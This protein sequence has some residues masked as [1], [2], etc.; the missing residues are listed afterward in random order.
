MNT[1]FFYGF[2]R[3]KGPPG[4]RNL[5]VVIPGELS[6]N[7]WAIE[8]ASSTDHATAL[9]HKQG[10]GN[11]AR[12]R[13]LFRRLLKGI[14]I[15]P[16]VAGV[17]FLSSG[18][19]DY[20]PALLAQYATAHG[21]AIRCFSLRETKCAAAMIRTA[22]A[23]A[24]VMASRIA[25]EQRSPFGADAL[26]IGLNCAGT[27]SASGITSHL[28]CGRAMDRLNDAGATIL[29]SEIPEM[30]GLGTEFLSRCS[31]KGVRIKLK[32]IIE[33]HRRRLAVRNENIDRN[34]LCAFNIAGGLTSLAAKAKISV[35]KAGN[36]PIM[37]VIEYGEAP[38]RS[39]LCVMDGPALS[40]FVMTGYMGSGAHLTINCCGVGQA[41]MA[42]VVVGA[43]QAS[44]ILPIIKITGSKY[45]FRQRANRI[46][47]SAG[48]ANS[49]A[50]NRQVV[51]LLKLIS[52]VASGKPTRT[53]TVAPYALNIPMKHYQA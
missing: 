42:P 44:P 21:R 1:T 30:I 36:A 45:Y 51:R 17:I 9:T 14:M 31:S 26:R 32:A 35:L 49:A 25:A 38:H 39:G 19:E 13:L 43:S 22:K 4:I 37:D 7:A 41:N 5:L 33:S 8:V 12:D 6:L 34:E 52:N 48:T 2:P 16:N 47:F 53:E 18:N 10:A 11:F 28:I 29:L 50:S 46:D 24:R 3:K 15:H 23:S 20:D 40:D 27:D